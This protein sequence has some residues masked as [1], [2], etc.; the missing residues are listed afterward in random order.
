M[1]MLFQSRKFRGLC[2][3]A[4]CA[5]IGYAFFGAG[6]DVAVVPN[7]AQA[8]LE[9]AP[10]GQPAPQ[11]QASNLFAILTQ[12][13]GR[14]ANLDPKE[15]AL[16]DSDY[17]GH[18]AY[19]KATRYLVCADY[20][21]SKK[22]TAQDLAE[23]GVDGQSNEALEFAKWFNV[24]KDEQCKNVTKADL[25]SVAALMHTAAQAGDVAAQ[26]YELGQEIGAL[27]QAA[28]ARMRDNPEQP[29]DLGQQGKSLLERANALAQ[30]GDRDAAFLAAKLSG[31]DEFGQKD[32]I[33]SAAWAMVG[34]QQKG[35][36]LNATNRVFEVETYAALSAEQRQ[37]A[38]QS[39]QVLYAR[40]CDK[41]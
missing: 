33:A 20:Q 23:Q 11:G 10:S 41:R 36:L 7:K 17:G 38:A 18:P 14:Y 19:N 31:S 22:D 25:Q 2:I 29:Q 26:S 12:G 40:C 9:A 28:E 35:E 5:L 21:A 3:L 32:L 39:A 24:L 6:A 16:K 30:R 4:V 15:Y 27:R 34:M 8:Q 13:G 37:T 1:K